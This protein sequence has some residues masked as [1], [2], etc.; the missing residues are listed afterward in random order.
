MR[1]DFHVIHPRLSS[2]RIHSFIIIPRRERIKKEEK[3]TA[4]RNRENKWEKI[5]PFSMTSTRNDDEV[6]RHF[7]A[8]PR[9][10]TQVFLVVKR[11]LY[12]VGWLERDRETSVSVS[13]ATAFSLLP[14]SL[15]FL[16]WG[17]QTKSA[18]SAEVGRRKKDWWKIKFRLG[19]P[20]QQ[21]QQQITE[22][23]NINVAKAV[24]GKQ[25]LKKIRHQGWNIQSGAFR[26]MIQTRCGWPTKKNTWIQFECVMCIPNFPNRWHSVT[27]ACDGREINSFSLFVHNHRFAFDFSHTYT[28]AWYRRNNNFFPV[29]FS[30]P[31]RQSNSTVCRFAM[32][33]VIVW[34]ER[35]SERNVWRQI[36]SQIICGLENEPFF[37]IH[38]WLL[39]RLFHCRFAFLFFTSLCCCQFSPH[40]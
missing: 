14:L 11:A 5:E 22:N 37:L 33:R 24:N 1:Y 6:S 12:A 39:W 21:Q 25:Q 4:H 40:Y 36:S 30:L 8:L 27:R 13:D 2:H 10:F 20:Q 23:I 3:N 18:E 16:C 34:C 17:C 28:F 29:S 19:E 7:S 31:T 38:F 26:N 32:A 9:V 15:A 35:E